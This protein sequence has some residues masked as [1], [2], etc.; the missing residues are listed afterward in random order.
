VGSFDGLPKIRLAAAAREGEAN[1]EL[2][3]FLA[4]ELGVP[5]S[6]V[7]IRSGRRSRRKSLEI[8]GGEDLERALERLLVVP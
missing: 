3:R 4:R 6:A 5:R 8:E 7:S 2:V 1:R